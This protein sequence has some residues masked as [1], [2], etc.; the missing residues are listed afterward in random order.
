ME[1]AA[2]ALELIA[3][4]GVR[5]AQLEPSALRAAARAAG[6][7][8]EATIDP[9]AIDT[10]VV[11]RTVLVA[12]LLEL[13]ALPFAPLPSEAIK[14][15][16]EKFNSGVQLPEFAR[17]STET[18]LRGAAG[19]QGLDGARREVAERWLASLCPLE[20]VLAVNPAGPP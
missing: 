10:G 3:G 19:P 13:G 18:A 17:L 8:T 20:S 5:P 11:A 14:T 6:G 9:S 7:E 4:L 2:A 1:R 16:K 15:F 12:S